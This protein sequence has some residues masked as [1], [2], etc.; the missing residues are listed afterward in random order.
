MTG[1]TYFR[2]GILFL[3][4]TLCS[5]RQ[6]YAQSQNCA[7]SSP[8]RHAPVPEIKI[9]IVGVEVEGENP[10]PEAVWAKLVEYIQ[11][12]RWA[13]PNEPDTNWIEEPVFLIRDQVRNQGYFRAEVSGRPYLVRALPNEKLYVLIVTMASGP[14]YKLGTIHFASA[15]DTP[16][17]FAEPLLRRQFQLQEGE[18]FDI[19]KIREGLETMSKLYSSKGYID[20]SS[21]PDS[22]I[23]EKRSRINLIIKVDEHKPYSISKMEILGLNPRVQ[24]QLKMPQEIGEAFNYALWER[25]FEESK[26]QLPPEAVFNKIRQ[27]S[28]NTATSTV[29][30][31][32]DFRPCSKTHPSDD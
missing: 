5:C 19:S 21:E 6:L 17:I 12:D 13:T 1:R 24:D 3:L 22:T 26:E 18:P 25:F 32:L 15:T 11:K 31:S 23:D 2:L 7:D 9:S 14:K 20:F 30:I 10:L 16:I 8:Q 28:R 29:E 4:G 27:I